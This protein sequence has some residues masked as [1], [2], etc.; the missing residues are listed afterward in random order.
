MDI[1]RNDFD[2]HLDKKSL[3]APAYIVLLTVFIQ[4]D[5]RTGSICYKTKD[6]ENVRERHDDL[7][8]RQ[9]QLRL[10]HF[11][12]LSFKGATLRSI[13]MNH[14]ASFVGTRREEKRFILRATY[15]PGAPSDTRVSY[16]SSCFIDPVRVN[17]RFQSDEANNP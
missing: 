10:Y 13:H 1:K 6:E 17:D 11:F 8:P 2:S 5:S 12:F 16:L 14:V 9:R 15:S 7:P 4:H 3:L